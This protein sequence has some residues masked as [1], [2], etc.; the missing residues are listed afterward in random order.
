MEAKIDECSE[1]NSRR[2]RAENKLDN[3]QQLLL[4]TN[5]DLV[6]AQSENVDLE[7]RL[8]M[9]EQMLIRVKAQWAESEHERAQLF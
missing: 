9:T 7:E 2:Q 1:L 8:V 3:A 5:L 6:G 4:Q